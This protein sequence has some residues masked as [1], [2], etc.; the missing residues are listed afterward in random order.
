METN[1]EVT[2][3]ISFLE[4]EAYEVDFCIWALYL[5]LKME[6]IH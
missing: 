6:D 1:I 5:H 3:T 4:F 2:Q